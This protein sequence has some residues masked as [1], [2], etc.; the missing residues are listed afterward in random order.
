[1]VVGLTTSYLTNRFLNSSW[2]G[3][4]FGYSLN[5]REASDWATLAGS[6]MNIIIGSVWFLFASTLPRR[7]TA[8]EGARV[9][10]F[11]AKMHQPVDFAREE[12]SAGS[13][14]AQARAMGGLCLIYGAFMILLMLIPNPLSGRLAFLFCGGVMFWIGAVLFRAGR[15]RQATSNDLQTPASA[16]GP[17]RADTIP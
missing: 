4:A 10:A 15:A 11:F 3:D 2:A 8:E 1:V 12:K 17:L 16:A 5:G 7:R 6:L 9:D 14:N 13:D